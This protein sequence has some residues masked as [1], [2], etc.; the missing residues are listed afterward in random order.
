MGQVFKA[1]VIKDNNIRFAS[2]MACGD[3]TC[4]NRMVVGHMKK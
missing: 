2:Q 4:F 3:D 1:D